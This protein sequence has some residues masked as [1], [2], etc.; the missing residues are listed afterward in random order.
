MS[1]N[2]SM[3][4]SSVTPAWRHRGNGASV[5][6]RRDG[7]TGAPSSTYEARR[8]VHTSIPHLGVELLLG[9]QVADGLDALGVVR[10]MRA[11]AHACQARARLFNAHTSVS[12]CSQTHA[13]LLSTSQYE[14][15]REKVSISP[16][17]ATKLL[18]SHTLATTFLNLAALILHY[19]PLATSSPSSHS[20]RA[21]GHIPQH[22]TTIL[23]LHL[24][25]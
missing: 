15:P 14:T 4:P 3:R 13:C 22:P 5:L 25:S 18:I 17:V 11:H 24:H 20:H 16:P 6:A 19:W 10:L 12:N 23:S 1:S 21:A 7:R 2:E 9:W 8:G